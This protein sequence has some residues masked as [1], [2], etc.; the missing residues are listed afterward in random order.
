MAS[1]SATPVFSRTNSRVSSTVHADPN[2]LARSAATDFSRHLVQQ[3]QDVLGTE[4][5]GAYLIGS[6]AH[7]GFSWRYS[8]I[9]VALVTAAGLSGQVLDRLRSVANVM[10]P[11]WGPK[12]SIFWTDRYFSLGRFPSLDRIDYLDHAITLIEGACVRPERPTLEAIQ[13]YL[14]GAP[15]ADWAGRARDF[16]AAETLEPKDHKAYLRALLYPGRFCYSWMTG[17]IGSNDD[18]VAFL[19]ERHVAGLDVNLIARALQCRQNAADPDALF[20]ARK[21]LSSQIDA[22]TALVN[23]GSGPIRPVPRPER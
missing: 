12:V 11:E 9:D 15:L 23:G 20:P 17:L 21:V 5:L 19:T 13:H 22:C 14:S 6:L 4:L 3:W 7:A 8:D 10:S 16:I 2:E 18:A 1:S